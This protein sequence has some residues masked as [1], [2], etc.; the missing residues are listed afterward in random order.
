MQLNFEQIKSVT[1]GATY[2]T[3]EPDGIIFNRFTREQHAM[4]EKKD[5]CFFE[6]G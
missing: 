1:W 4:Y 3:E 6:E 5:I 2:F